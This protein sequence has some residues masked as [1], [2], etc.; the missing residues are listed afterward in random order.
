MNVSII[1]RR[2][3]LPE[4]SI[5]FES[6]NLCDLCHTETET[7]THIF[8]NCS[9]TVT[10]IS[11]IE[12][13]INTSLNLNIIFTESDIILGITYKTEYNEILN[14]I[15]LTIKKYIYYTKY[16]KKTLSVIIAKA[17]IKNLI[18]SGLSQ[19]RPPKNIEIFERLIQ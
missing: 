13:W 8:W 5:N 18:K 4:N 7:L 12:H 1:K 11:E 2:H 10:L 16:K 15:I 17:A 9:K 19:N 6:L 3:N 14:L